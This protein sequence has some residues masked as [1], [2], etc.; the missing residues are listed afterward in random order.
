MVRSTRKFSLSLMM[1]LVAVS[2]IFSYFYS[3]GTV[4]TITIQV[5]EKERI[6]EA[7]GSGENQSISSKYLVFTKDHDVLENTDSLLWLKWNSSSVQGQL[8]E[9]E[10]YTVKV[11]GWRIGLLSMYPN[12]VSI[13]P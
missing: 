3:F 10:T 7:S 4:R 6:V 12:I 2:I 11:Y 8:H 1:G 5:T 13:E 9:G